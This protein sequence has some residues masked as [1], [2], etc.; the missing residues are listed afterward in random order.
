MEHTAEG[1]RMSDLISRQDAID[2]LTEHFEYVPNY[3][4]RARLVVEQLLSAEPQIIRCKDCIESYRWI[5]G[6]R[7]CK[8]YK[9]CVT[10]NDFCSRAERREDGGVA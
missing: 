7:K 2:A 5:I 3:A 4:K 10:D 6:I 1:E 8:R 9:A